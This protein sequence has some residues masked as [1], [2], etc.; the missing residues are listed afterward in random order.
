MAFENIIVYNQ[1][2]ISMTLILT[3][4]NCSPEMKLL[5]SFLVNCISS[6]FL[7]CYYWKSEFLVFCSSSKIKPWSQFSFWAKCFCLPL[8]PAEASVG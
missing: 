5:N 2:L 3:D 8:V 4:F 7:Y 1:N 6:C